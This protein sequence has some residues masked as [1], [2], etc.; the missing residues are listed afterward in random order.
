MGRDGKYCSL[1]LEHG[2]SSVDKKSPFELWFGKKPGIKHLRVIGTRCDVPVPDQKRRKLDK[3]AQTCVLIGS[4]GDVWN[5]DR[6]T[7]WRSRDVRFEQE[8]LLS[9]TGT[10]EVPVTLEPLGA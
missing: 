9:S 2:V 1:Y 6:N 3:K 8:K 5:Q 7:V 4:D 10:G